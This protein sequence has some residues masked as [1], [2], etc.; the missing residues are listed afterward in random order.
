MTKP[1]IGDKTPQQSPVCIKTNLEC[2]D[3]QRQNSPS[4]IDLTYI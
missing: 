4:K 3:T 2:P 1:G